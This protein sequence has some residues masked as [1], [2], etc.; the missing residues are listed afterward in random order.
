MSSLDQWIAPFIRT[1]GVATIATSA[2]LSRA[3]QKADNSPAAGAMRRPATL[4]EGKRNVAPSRITLATANPSENRPLRSDVAKVADV[5]WE[6]ADWQEFYD[7]RAGVA[8]YDG[9]QPREKAEWMA[10]ESCITRWL[11]THPPV[12][13]DDAICPHCRQPNDAPNTSCVPTLS[14]DNGYV[15]LHHTCLE[16]WR[17]LRRQEAVRALVNMGIM[18]QKSSADTASTPRG[19]N[20][21]SNSIVRPVW[22]FTH[23]WP[24]VDRGESYEFRN[25]FGCICSSP[26][27]QSTQ[28]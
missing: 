28:E 2:T 27:M 8:E 12:D 16:P 11:D 18:R 21:K 20:C 9:R 1:D 4:P 24:K 14:G 22:G 25:L 6:A 3:P 10:Y 15:W 19:F 17:A 23:S 26:R 13:A 5:A 7:E